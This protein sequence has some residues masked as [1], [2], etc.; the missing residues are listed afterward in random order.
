MTTLQHNVLTST[1]PIL[2]HL[3]CR[4][5]F[6][7]MLCRDCIWRSRTCRMSMLLSSSLS[8]DLSCTDAVLSKRLSN[9]VLSIVGA[10]FVASSTVACEICRFFSTSRSFWESE[11]GLR[12]AQK[13][14]ILQY[15]RGLNWYP[16][17]LALWGYGWILKI[18]WIRRKV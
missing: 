9:S 14:L 13:L 5:T 4:S 16:P 8:N 2:L 3:A 6:V 17:K 11:V 18:Y 10:V 7:E 1:P 15:F 12:P